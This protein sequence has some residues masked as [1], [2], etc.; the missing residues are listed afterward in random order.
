MAVLGEGLSSVFVPHSTQTFSARLA[1][2]SQCPKRVQPFIFYHNHSHSWQIL[3]PFQLS[4]PDNMII[5]LASSR[6]SHSTRCGVAVRELFTA[7]S[8]W[9]DWARPPQRSAASCVCG[10]WKEKDRSFSS[11]THWRRRVCRTPH[12][13]SKTDTLFICYKLI[14]LRQT[15]WSRAEPGKG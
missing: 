9:R 7:P 11:A 14:K 6:R 8:P 10:R 3:W 1:N 5:I 2:H 12:A 15:S 4:S 13:R